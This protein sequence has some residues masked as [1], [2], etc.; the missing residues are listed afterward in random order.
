MS[1]LTTLARPY[2]EAVFKL[3]LEKG[4]L[5]QWSRTLEFLATAMGDKE[6]A[7]MAQNP[8]VPKGEF[9]RVLFDVGKGYLDKGGENF[10]RLLVH[11]GR[12]DLVGQIRELFESYR[13]GHEG[14]VDVKVTT[15]YPLTEEDQEKLISAL[16]KH[17]GK[18]VHLQVDQDRGLIGGVI[19]R[20]GDKVIDGSVRGRLERMAKRLYS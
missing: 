5:E 1:E 20:A 3:A 11:N 10:I 13:A 15:A 19:I 6:L 2:A 14:Y 7:W 4:N 9:L 12:I 17:L 18:K 8:N 16:E